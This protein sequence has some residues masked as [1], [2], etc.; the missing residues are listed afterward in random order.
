MPTRKDKVINISPLGIEMLVMFMLLDQ[1]E[2]CRVA[3]ADDHATVVL[4]DD[5]AH[6]TV[7]TLRVTANG[8][9]KAADRI[10]AMIAAGTAH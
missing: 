7:E 6:D 8:L 4:G 9:V 1:L 10:A 2:Q 5:R 3:A